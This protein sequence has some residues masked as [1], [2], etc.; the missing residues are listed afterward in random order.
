MAFQRR[1]AGCKGPSS[2]PRQQGLLTPRIG[3]AAA[4]AAEECDRFI[5]GVH[6]SGVVLVGLENDAEVVPGNADVARYTRF[7]GLSA[8]RPANKTRAWRIA[9]SAWREVAETLVDVGDALGEAIL[10]A[11]PGRRSCRA[12]TAD[13]SS[14]RPRQGAHFLELWHIFETLVGRLE[15]AGGPRRRGHRGSVFRLLTLTHGN[16]ALSFGLPAPRRRRRR[17]F[18]PPPCRRHVPLRIGLPVQPSLD[19]GTPPFLAGIQAAADEQAKDGENDAQQKTGQ[20]RTAATPLDGLL[21]GRRGAGLDRLTVEEAA[22]VVGARL[23]TGECFF[24]VLLEALQTDGFEVCARPGWSC[25]G[26]SGSALM[27]SW[28]VSMTVSPR[29]GGRLAS[30]S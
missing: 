24:C 28:R 13:R 29:K 4:R 22:Q 11:A 14:G 19:V 9:I 17:A 15:S 2:R 20:G 25:V 16:E 3:I 8:S 26:G 12:D 21:P 10:L 1:P 23:G 27:T 18:P 30:R 6:R 7:V 5:E